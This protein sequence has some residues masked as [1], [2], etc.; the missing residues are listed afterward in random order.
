MEATRE[1]LPF[2]PDLVST[3]KSV[4]PFIPNA[5]NPVIH[6]DQDGTD[7]DVESWIKELSDDPE[8]VNL[9][10]QII[11]ACLRPGVAWRRLGLLY[12]EK[13]N[14]GKGT[15]AELVRQVVGASR[16]ASIP[17]AD[18]GEDFLLEPLTQAQAIVV[19]ENDVGVFLDRAANLKSVVTGDMISINRKFLS[20]ITYRFLGF[21]LQCVNEL[22]RFKDKTASIYRRQL[23]IPM[24]KN[25]KG[26][27][28]R[29][30][31]DDY[32]TRPEVRQYVLWRVLEGMP[33]YYELSEP[34]ACKDALEQLKLANDPVRDFWQEFREQFV[35][36][37]LPFSFLYDLYKAWYVRAHN[38][39]T[40]TSETGFT[41]SLFGILDEETNPIFYCVDRNADH[42]VSSRM[43]DTEL[44]IARYDLEDW[45]NPG[46]PGKDP[47]LKSKPI[48]QPKYRGLLRVKP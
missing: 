7:W 39:Q 8:I 44:L 35:W 6:N 34:Q 31:K 10:W 21:M 22:P 40:K 5:V 1:L 18:F 24:L 26:I 28:R 38:S 9:L 33:T 48:L 13:G 36:D 2:S 17:L 25:F 3:S 46:Y 41:T 19:D 42:R 37:L 12:S 47:V 43:H 11:C 45:T 30:I 14:N 16:C 23:V 27:E 29:Y 20:P 15:F 32:I 4:T